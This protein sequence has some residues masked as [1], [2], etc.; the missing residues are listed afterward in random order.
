MGVSKR[1]C[2]LRSFVLLAPRQARWASY[3]N[4]Q[5]KRRASFQIALASGIQNKI[6]AISVRDRNQTVTFF[7]SCNLRL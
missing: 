6:A 3:E 4:E 1:S 2:F 7:Y 5:S